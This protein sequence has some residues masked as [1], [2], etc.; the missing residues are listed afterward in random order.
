MLPK[1]NGPGPVRK[2]LTVPPVCPSGMGAFA[3]C[4]VRTKVKPVHGAEA[5]STRFSP[6]ISTSAV[7]RVLITSYPITS[8]V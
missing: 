1:L 7:I 6:S 4:A 2:T 5:T 3:S 8:A